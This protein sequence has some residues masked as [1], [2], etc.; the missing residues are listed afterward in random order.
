[1]PIPAAFSPNIAY[2][3]TIY[4]SGS[5]EAILQQQ[6]FLKRIDAWAQELAPGEERDT[7]AERIKDAYQKKSTELLLK[8]LNLST[9]PENIGALTLLTAIDLDDN[10]LATLPP[11]IGN[12]KKLEELHVQS[13]CLL[14][15]PNT[16]CEL[17]ALQVLILRDNDL[18]F[19]PDNIGQLSC[20]ECLDVTM[21]ALQALPD[22]IGDLKKLGGLHVSHNYLR[23]LPSAVSQLTALV[24]LNASDNRID[25]VPSDIGDMPNLERLD[26]QNNRLFHRSFSLEHVEEVYLENNP[27]IEIMSAPYRLANFGLGLDNTFFCLHKACDYIAFEGWGIQNSCFINQLLQH[28]GRLQEQVQSRAM[29]NTVG[30]YVRHLRAA[31]FGIKEVAALIHQARDIDFLYDS[32]REDLVFIARDGKSGVIM[33]KDFYQANILGAS[34]LADI[35]WLQFSSYVFDEKKETYTNV[36]IRDIA[37]TLQPFPFLQKQFLA[38]N[39]LNTLK[40]FL[41]QLKLDKYQELFISALY[42]RSSVVDLITPENQT[43]LIDLFSPMVSHK[44]GEIT[45]TDTHFQT[46][47]DAFPLVANEPASTLFSLAMLMTRYSSRAVFGTE[48]ESPVALRHYALALLNKAIQINPN[49]IDAQRVQNYRDSLLQRSDAQGCTEQLF[50]QMLSDTQDL[51]AAGN[52]ELKTVVAAI[53]PLSWR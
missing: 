36:P 34:S 33:G 27:V 37:A 17:Q 53:L 49:L 4:D 25:W 41:T 14:V 18:K 24:V 40:K 29:D 30:L 15:L 21:N 46:I 50:D 39:H 26:L 19:L 2:V 7:A 32:E 23:S 5:V 47:L 3:P 10:Q 16:L 38:A 20:L 44:N 43:A 35:S 51:I 9:L 22:S 48:L 11:S 8:N 6:D 1:M 52:L 28:A 13:N 45:I 31:Y 12:L 42:C